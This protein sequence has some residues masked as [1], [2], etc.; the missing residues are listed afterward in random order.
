MKMNTRYALPV[1]WLILALMLGLASQAGASW[2]Y[3]VCSTINGAC[4]TMR[5]N[6]QFGCQDWLGYCVPNSGYPDQEPY[7]A[8]GEYGEGVGDDGVVGGVCIQDTES[9]HNAWDFFEYR[10][11][12]GITKKSYSTEAGCNED[13]A[14]ATKNCQK[15]RHCT[16]HL[17][18]ACIYQGNTYE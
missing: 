7:G 8:C 17:S 18:Q 15:N 10:I 6:S 9:Y 13:L 3:Q 2:Y 4:T 11:S 5:Y 1:L 14:A 16:I 12:G